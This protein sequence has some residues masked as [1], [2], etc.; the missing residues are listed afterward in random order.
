MNDITSFVYE[1]TYA[2]FKE[3]IVVEEYTGQTEYEFTLFTNGLTL[4]EEYGSYYLADAEGNVEATIGDIIVFTADERNNTMGSMTCETVRANQEYVLTIHLDAEYLADEDTV[5]PIRI[6]PTI[7]INYDNNGA[8]AIE[9]VT[10]NQNSTFSG[11]SGS[12]YVG[13]HPAGS[14]SRV[15]MRFP[16]LS[17]N[18]IA[19]DQITA[20]TV[21]L[22][23]L[24][25][26]GDEDITVEC[27][28][29]NKTSPDWSEAGTTTWSSVGT[30]YLGSLL[31]SHV[32]SYGQ[33]NVGNHRYS[34]NILTAAKAWA[35]GT[36]S[37]AKGLVFKANSTFENQTGDAIKTWY[38]TF[39]AYNRSDYRPSLT[40]DYTNIEGKEYYIAFQSDGKMLTASSSYTLSKTTYS[41]SNSYQKWIFT[42]VS[43]GVYIIRM[44]NN[45]NKCLTA[46]PSSSTITI[47]NVSTGN[48]NQHWKMNISSDGN[49]LQSKSTNSSVK[50]K[51]MYYNGVSFTLSNTSY[52]AVGF[53]DSSWF[54]PCTSMSLSTIYINAGTSRY[55]Y[56]TC[57][58]TNANVTSGWALAYTSSSS[59]VFTVSDGKITA[60][61]AGVATLTIRNKVTGASC[62]AN[63]YVTRLPNPDAQNKDMWCWAA[64]S[65][66]VGEHNG[67]SGALG[68]GATLLTYNDGLLTYN[69]IKYFGQ[70]S[71]LQNTCDTGQRQIVVDVHGDD[72]SEGGSN[73]DKEQAL[74]FASKNSMSIDTLGSIFGTGLSNSNINTM[75]N[76]LANGRWVIGNVFTASGS[77]HSIVIQS[78]NSST[79]VYTY[80][81]PW[82]NSIGTFTSTQLENDT[83]RLTS[84]SADR[85]LSWIQYCR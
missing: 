15:L 6:D 31:D 69:G 10:I 67:G 71:S 24:M 32:I 25:C 55:V 40:I 63:V 58:P 59:S 51:K 35:N 73:A 41:G 23:D 75:K 21:E 77:G 13:R 29:Y 54:V 39:A 46:V 28:I 44:K 47:S 56:P 14:L 72:E 18:G 84:S 78:F 7:E 3:D 36:Q 80:W 26:Q 66:M 16:N 62:T 4:C 12:L 5:Y 27:R 34:F 42:E 17:L 37:P 33:G 2:G 20:A 79:N 57:Y 1:L 64:C 11:T 52:S 53:I 19:A 22:R 48:T 9:D 43:S 82:T 38:K 81:D 50:D 45:I 49:G 70:T 61:D 76:E 83:I 68:T 74:Q 85:E 8:G 30:S 65:K 60:K